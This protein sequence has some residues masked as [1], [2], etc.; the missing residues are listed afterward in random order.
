MISKA[1]NVFD[2]DSFCEVYIL[3][4][5]LIG[6]LYQ[7]ISSHKISNR[8]IDIGN[9]CKSLGPM[10]AD[11]ISRS[12]IFTDCDQTTLFYK[13]SKAEFYQIFGNADF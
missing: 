6:F 4:P 3:T 7:G 8:H 1:K 2:M 10:R 11:A 9:T 5:E 13:I 12:H